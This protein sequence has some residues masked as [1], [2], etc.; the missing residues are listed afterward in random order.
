MSDE[1]DIMV[2]CGGKGTRIRPL[3]D[4]YL[5]KSLIPLGGRPAIEYVLR[6][7]RCAT[8]GRIILCVDRGALVAPLQD[9]IERNGLKEHSVHHGQWT[10]AHASYV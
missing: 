8:G 4:E 1:L 9:V 7:V 5:C 3:A 6:A 10:W 2:I